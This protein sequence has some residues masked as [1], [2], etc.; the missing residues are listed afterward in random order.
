MDSSK[1]ADVSVS[2]VTSYTDSTTEVQKR[3]CMAQQRERE[4]SPFSCGSK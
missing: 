1:V 2:Q 4:R 3:S